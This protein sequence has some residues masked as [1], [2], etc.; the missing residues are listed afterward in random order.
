MSGSHCFFFVC[1]L[2]FQKSSLQ[3]NEGGDRKVRGM[4]GS[5]LVHV[6]CNYRRVPRASIVLP[7]VISGSLAR[8][9]AFPK[10][11]G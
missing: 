3:T 7:N 5:L 6:S 10:V 2:Q 4:V 9:G 11:S 1:A 8:C